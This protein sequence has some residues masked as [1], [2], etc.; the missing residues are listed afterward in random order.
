MDSIMELERTQAQT[1]RAIW[2]YRRYSAVE[3]SGRPSYHHDPSKA[4]L[5]VTKNSAQGEDSD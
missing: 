4:S 2:K 1:D 3:P 5:L